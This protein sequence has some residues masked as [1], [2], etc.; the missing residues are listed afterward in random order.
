[1]R[2]ELAPKQASDR[3]TTW[4]SASVWDRSVIWNA[5]HGDAVDVVWQLRK[6]LDPT[7]ILDPDKILPVPAWFPAGAS[8]VL[9]EPRR[10]DV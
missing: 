10:F 5:E 6:A 4:E 1:M 8:H 7:N 3:S 2:D 9:D